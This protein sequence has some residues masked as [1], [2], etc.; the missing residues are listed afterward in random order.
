MSAESGVPLQALPGSYPEFMRDPFR[1]LELCSRWLADVESCHPHAGHQRIAEILREKPEAL[2]VTLN[3]DG[4]HQRSGCGRVL[5]LHGNMKRQRCEKCGPV[6]GSHRCTGAVRPDIYWPGETLNSRVLES[7]LE[8]LRDCD[9]LI[10]VGTSGTVEPTAKVPLEAK[11]AHRI[12]INP[13][14][15]VMSPHYHEHWRGPASQMLLRL[16]P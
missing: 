13:V 14:E 8:A 10:T 15:T 12:E 11:R 1:I 9:L 6:E 2:V 5:E 7:A 16:A 4:L 3:V